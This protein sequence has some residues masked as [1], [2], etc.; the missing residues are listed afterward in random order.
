MD[1]VPQVLFGVGAGPAVG[2]APVPFPVPGLGVAKVR[3]AQTSGSWL[4]ESVKVC[5]VL[6]IWQR[7]SS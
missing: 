3:Q 1:G 6:T 5:K 7:K 4:G 2:G